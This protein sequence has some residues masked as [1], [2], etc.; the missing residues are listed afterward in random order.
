MNKIV[1]MLLTISLA[2]TNVQASE[3]A[4][5]ALI[6]R[7][8]AI[9]HLS[10]DKALLRQMSPIYSGSE[11]FNANDMDVS[12]HP[13]NL[14]CW[15]AY[16][17]GKSLIDGSSSPLKIGVNSKRCLGPQPF[18]LMRPVYKKDANPY[19]RTIISCLI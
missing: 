14:P 13:I 9:M 5:A 4:E 12:L 10:F 8:R 1:L 7:S 15:G 17:S 6:P 16:S 3:L 19:P 2:N 18:Y 11:I